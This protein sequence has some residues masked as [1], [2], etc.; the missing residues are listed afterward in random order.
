MANHTRTATNENITAYKFDLN[1]GHACNF[2]CK[3][4]FN[5]L[6]TDTDTPYDSAFMSPETID[7]SIQYMEN[8]SHNLPEKEY[9]TLIPVF[10]GGEPLLYL[11]S[12]IR[13]FV[14]GFMHNKQVK[15][16]SLVTNGSLI[17][18]I[19]RDLL[20]L[21]RETYNDLAISV[22]YDYALQNENRHADTYNKVRRGIA[23]LCNNDF[24]VRTITVL[25]RNALHRFEDIAN[26]MIPLLR[27][28]PEL[29]VVFNID[30]TNI[31]AAPYDEAALRKTLQ[32]MKDWKTNH[33]VLAKRM[34]VNSIMS[35]KPYRFLRDPDCFVADVY[36]AIDVNGDCL[37]ACNAIY[38]NKK[39]RDMIT[40][41]N[42]NKDSF[43]TIQANRQALLDKVSQ[44]KMPKECQG[45]KASCR[46]MPWRTIKTDIS[47]WDGPAKPENCKLNHLLA[48][49]FF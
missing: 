33:M 13:P 8:L 27:S 2:R 45:C 46:V 11:N 32:K 7:K 21:Q 29:R 20:Q 38:T 15:P 23:W 22:S 6:K 12:V 39:I 34:V 25:T 37:P 36:G 47:E 17:M 30:R 35:E 26:D 10:F 44:Y 18:D 42:V 1:V 3:Y 16:Y 49:Y 48:E 40:Y 43:E 24:R 19:R 14:K 28:F 9:S 5:Q 4:C 31:Q 41:G